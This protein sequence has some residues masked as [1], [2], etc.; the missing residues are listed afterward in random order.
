[1][2]VMSIVGARPQFVKLA[3]IHWAS[4][5][6][7][8]HQILHTGQHYDPI[9]SSS[10][11]KILEIPDP[12]FNLQIGSGTHGVQTGKMLIEIEDIL[13]R[14]KPEH[15][16]IYG[17]TNTTLAGALAAS[18]LHIPISHIEAGLRS[19]N[20]QMPE[21]LNRITADHLS[22]LLFAPTLQSMK[23]LKREGL[24]SKALLVGDVML[25]SLRFITSKLDNKLNTSNFLFATIHR[26]ENTDDEERIRFVV[27]QLRR[28]PV[29]IHL[30]CHPRLEKVLL[31]LGILIDC[32]KLKFFPPLDYFSTIQKISN[33]CGVITD[34]GGLQKEAYLLNKPCLVVRNET[35]W[36]E[37]LQSGRNFLD[38]E[39]GKI[40][41]EW[42]FEFN[43]LPSG[44]V[45]GDGNSARRIV[46]RILS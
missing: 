46:S 23:N 12:A 20:I 44:E 3:P 26:A 11:F 15:I 22:N 13:L 34:S 1:M 25:E 24:N 38:P 4:K 19:Y 16:I 37:T 36:V 21:E 29:E 33:S 43:E 39:L 18:K 35:E 27:S 9:L 45:F 41:Q 31:N 40:E 7:F 2:R 42:W 8:S 17:D 10:F 14:E 5:N 32:P 6:N 30:H 28:S